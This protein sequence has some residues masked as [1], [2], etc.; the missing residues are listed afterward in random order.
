MKIDRRFFMVAGSTGAVAGLTMPQGETKASTKM[1]AV[2]PAAL[3]HDVERRTFNFF[4][5]TVNKANGLIPDRWPGKSACNVSVVGFAL[6]AWGVG[7]E[8]TWITRDE[9]RSVTLTTLKFFD[10]LPMGEDVSGMAGYKGFYYHYLDFNTGLRAGVSEM[11]S[12]DVALLHMGFLF[13]AEFFATDHA[14]EVEIRRLAKKLVDL[15]EWNWLQKNGQ[16]GLIPMNWTP[17]TGFSAWVWRGYSE[18]KC[19]YLLAE[20]SETHPVEPGTWEKWQATWPNNW[21]LEGDMRHIGCAPLFTHQ[22]TEMWVDFRGIQDDLMR[23]EALDYF[24]NS[25]RATYANQDYCIRNPKGWKGYAAHVWGLTACNGP[26]EAKA[27][28]NGK[29]VQFWRYAMRGPDTSIGGID[30]GT[31]APTAAVTSIGLTPEISIPCMV[32]MYEAYGGAI[33]G[34]FGFVQSFNRSFTYPFI[35]LTGGGR[36]HKRFGWV[37]DAIFSL[38]HGSM[39]GMIANYRAETVWKAM[40]T[41][42]H[43]RRCLRAV[44]FSGG[45]L[46]LYRSSR[47]TEHQS[48]QK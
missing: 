5:Q 22:Y 2:D 33:Y 1:P 37:D 6:V 40:R 19:M 24:E 36:L 8:R 28:Y 9:A 18:A 42:A 44:K 34:E 21:T 31:I 47:N 39:I 30:D 14:D 35:P 27:T 7:A 46:S 16:D 15:S 29:D 12:I 38:E 45:W 25:R 13:S 17:E 20:G 41:S 26:A 3:L 23:R 10:S 32:K 4:W 48:A 11:S 43:L